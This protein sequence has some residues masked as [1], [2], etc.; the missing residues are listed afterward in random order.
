MH[1]TLFSFIPK[2]VHIL[3]YYGQVYV[4]WLNEVLIYIDVQ[5]E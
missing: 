3:L 5:G 1:A 2:N 4:V